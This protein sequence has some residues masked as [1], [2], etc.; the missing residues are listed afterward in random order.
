MSMD[1]ETNG[2][3]TVGTRTRERMR[4]MGM[5]AT[6]VSEVTEYSLTR[7]AFQGLSGPVD[8]TGSRDFVACPS[9]TLFIYSLT[10]HPRGVWRIAEP[11]LRMLLTRQVAA[12]MKRLK[13][14]I[15]GMKQQTQTACAIAVEE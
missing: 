4:S 13:L 5:S 6:T 11:L 14:Q 2:P 10:L 9:G 8:C 7:T 12:D 15:E 1:Y 3:P